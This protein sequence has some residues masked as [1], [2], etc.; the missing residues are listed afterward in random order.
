M[1]FLKAKK[2]K[3]TYSAQHIVGAPQWLLKK[4]LDHDPLLWS[5]LQRPPRGAAV[6]LPE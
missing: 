6:T 5:S 2:K 4:E 1:Y 3:K